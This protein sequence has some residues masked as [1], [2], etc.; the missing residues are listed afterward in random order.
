[1]PEG[2]QAVINLDSWERPAIFKWLQ[3]QG[4]IADA[5]MLRTFNCGVGMIVCVPA[6]QAD[7]TL[8]ILNQH[9]RGAFEIGSIRSATDATPVVLEGAPR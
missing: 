3:Q 2:T 1:L 5:E 8:D 6:E 7:A 9:N 4:N